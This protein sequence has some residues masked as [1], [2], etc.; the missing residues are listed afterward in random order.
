MKI[1]SRTVAFSFLSIAVLGCGASESGPYRYESFA[2]EVSAQSSNTHSSDEPT[3]VQLASSSE[4]DSLQSKSALSEATPTKTSAK[5]DSARKIIY[6][7]NVNLIVKSFAGVENSILDLTQQLGG[8]VARANISGKTG[9]SRQGAWT[10]RVPTDQYRAFLASAGGLGEITSLNEHTKEVTAEFH[11]VDARIRNKQK[12]EQRLNKILEE[13]PGKLT[14]VLT[15]EREVSRVREEIERMQG[16]LR[17]LKDLT[18]YSTISITVTE[19]QL[20][21]PPSTPTFGMLIER[22]WTSTVESMTLAFQTAVLWIIAI[23][24]WMVII[25]LICSLGA[26]AS[27]RF[28]A[29]QVA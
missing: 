23:G 3:E 12:E 16:R 15:V 13:R 28:N 6:T 24:P 27:R 8:F 22:Q 19:I 4:A 26:L 17:V 21:V 9:D 25:G 2:D 10:V 18:S 1:V 14:D 5:I 11:D 7:A 29:K 20:Y